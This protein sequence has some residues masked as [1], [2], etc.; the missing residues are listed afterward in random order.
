MNG[1]S[2]VIL[3]FGGKALMITGAGGGAFVN[4]LGAASFQFQ[5]GNLSLSSALAAGTYSVSEYQRWL[6]AA[7]S[8]EC[9]G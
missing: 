5:N 8:A 1:A 4:N 9:C 6:L 3:N 2:D 7:A